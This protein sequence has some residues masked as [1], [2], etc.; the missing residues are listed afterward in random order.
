MSRYGYIVSPGSKQMIWLGK[1]ICGTDREGNEAV[2]RFHIGDAGEPANY[3]RDQ[4]NRVLWRFLAE[5]AGK[6]LRVVVEGDGSSLDGF[7]EIGGEL[8]TDISFEEYL[9]DPSL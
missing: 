6:E 8:A 4:L 5:N 9:K 2:A 7:S 1:A 3:E